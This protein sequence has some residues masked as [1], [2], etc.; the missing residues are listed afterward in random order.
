MR[1]RAVLLTLVIAAGCLPML[2]GKSRNKVKMPK[3]QPHAAYKAPKG[4]KAPKIKSSKY[5]SAKRSAKPR[6]H[7]RKT[8]TPPR[9]V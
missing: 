5:K 2:E 1:L 7:V 6:T 4:R 9:V 3:S 8:R